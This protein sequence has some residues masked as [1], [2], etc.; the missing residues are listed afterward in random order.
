M[1]APVTT[2]VLWNLQEGNDVSGRT[3]QAHAPNTRDLIVSHAPGDASFTGSRDPCTQI[4][5]Q[6]LR[7]YPS[8]V[9]RSKQ[10]RGRANP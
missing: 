1:D 10:H 6:P 8:R 5:T 7:G 4:I 2:D 3:K 9:M